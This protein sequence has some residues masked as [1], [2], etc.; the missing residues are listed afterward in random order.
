MPWSNSSIGYLEFLPQFWRALATRL[1]SV[2]IICACQ[3]P[4]PRRR[5]KFST[6]R[7]GSSHA[8]P[9]FFGLHHGAIDRFRPSIA[10]FKTHIYALRYS[11]PSSPLLGEEVHHLNLLPPPF[12]I[13]QPKKWKNLHFFLHFVID[14]WD[15]SRLVRSLDIYSQTTS[16]RDVTWGKHECTTRFICSFCR[17]CWRWC[18]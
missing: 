9:P 11:I 4:H 6:S 1:T 17:D 5:S 10:T 16:R 8:H 18:C 14:F 13:D 7:A 2:L 15:R 12:W 3:V